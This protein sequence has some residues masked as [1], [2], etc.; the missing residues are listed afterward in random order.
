VHWQHV[1]PLALGFLLFG[2]EP[3]LAQPAPSE[4]QQYQAR[5]N[6]AVRALTSHPSLKNVP[7]QKRQQLASFVIGNVSFV[8]LH[9]MA[10]ALVHELNLPVLGREE[11]AADTFAIVTM[12]KLGTTS[13][14]HPMLAEA[15]KAWFLTDKRDKREGTQPDAYDAHGLD[16][17]RAYRIVCLMVGSNKEEF[18]DLANQ[19]NLPEERQETCRLYDFPVASSSWLNALQS[20]RRGS[21]QPK[22]QIEVKYF[23]GK[24]DLNVYEQTFRVVQP[25]ETIANYAAEELSWPNPLWLEMATC[26]GP[27]AQFRPSTRNLIFCYEL[28]HDF[29]QLYRDYGQEWQAP[30][31]EKWWHPKW[32]KRAKKE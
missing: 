22:Q 8:L 17:Q 10:H 26:G 31:K 18:K 2:R 3:V 24:G 5:V 28:A 21:E 13:A 14:H 15:A 23:P 1:F 25:L 27:D 16:E 32:W 11:D 12:L 30:P 7:E 9:E 29:A 19:T 20:H 6:E 4:A